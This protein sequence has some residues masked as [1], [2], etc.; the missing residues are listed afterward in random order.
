MAND[1]EQRAGLDGVIDN[2]TLYLKG[3]ISSQQQELFGTITN[4]QEELFGTISILRSGSSETYIGPYD[5]TPK[6]TSQTLE[7]QNLL[8]TRNVEVES[9][10]YVEVQNPQGGETVTIG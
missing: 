6:V 2:E 7:T 1:I 3:T 5:V 9:I 8:M 10:P 4:Q